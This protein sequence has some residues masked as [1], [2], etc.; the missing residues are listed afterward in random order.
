M[1]EDDYITNAQRVA[2]QNYLAEEIIEAGHD[3]EQFIAF[4]GKGEEVDI[5]TWSFEELQDIVREFIRAKREGKLPQEEEAS[6]EEE[7]SSEQSPTHVESVEEEIVPEVTPGQQELSDHLV[8]R[9]MQSCIAED[10]ADEAL[11]RSEDVQEED[12]D[13]KER[14][15]SE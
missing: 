2:K 6:L 9:V 8:N 1:A 13:P 14:P 4:A 5:D 12:P 11:L 10:I 7:D 3:P 15:Q